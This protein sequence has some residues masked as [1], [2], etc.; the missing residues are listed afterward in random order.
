M[1]PILRLV[2]GGRA[3]RRS[4]ATNTELRGKPVFLLRFKLPTARGFAVPAI[5]AKLNDP[6]FFY[7]SIRLLKP[8][9]FETFCESSNV[10]PAK[11]CRVVGGLIGLII[12]QPT[13]RQH[14]LIEI[15]N[16]REKS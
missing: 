8:W 6:N 7:S 5:P 16:G 13:I 1:L 3:G 2:G 14:G 4:G 10:K 15:Q 11:G 9:Q 12:E